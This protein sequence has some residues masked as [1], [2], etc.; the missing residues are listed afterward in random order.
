KL[1]GLAHPGGLPRP[2]TADND[3]GRAWQR[4]ELWPDAVVGLR[5][6]GTG[7][8]EVQVLNNDPQL[9]R[10]R[11]ELTTAGQPAGQRELLVAAGIPVPADAPGQQL[12]NF[13]NDTALAVWLIAWAE[14][15]NL[16]EPGLPVLRPLPQPL[17]AGQRRGIAAALAFVMLALCTAHYW[18]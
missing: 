1:A 18:W 16:K 10:W 9:G 3:P 6:T 4:I 11:N 13:D 2:L 8:P 17:S 15:T 7:L 12:I 5:G 14:R